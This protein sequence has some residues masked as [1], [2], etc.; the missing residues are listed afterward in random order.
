RRVT[1]SARLDAH[2]K[3]LGGLID[4]SKQFEELFRMQDRVL[5]WGQLDVFVACGARLFTHQL[6]L[7]RRLGLVL[8]TR[9][10]ATVASSGQSGAAGQSERTRS[11]TP[12]AVVATCGK[13]GASST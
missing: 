11:G 5:H 7:P 9:A 2:L 10:S 3:Q 4:V 13:P 6:V 1:L 8:A 12:T